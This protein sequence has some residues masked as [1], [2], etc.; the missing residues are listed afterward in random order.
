MKF[1]FLTHQKTKFLN[2]K[3][4]ITLSSA[5]RQQ[6]GGQFPVEKVE[7]EFTTEII[8]RIKTAASAVPEGYREKPETKRYNT[9]T[10]KTSINCISVFTGHFEGANSRYIQELLGHKSSKTTEI[11][12]HGCT[13]SIQNITSPFDNL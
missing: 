3:P 13:K 5:N 8:H 9:N 4:Q 2:Q 10:G 6:A 12:T 1:L 11:Y 7:F